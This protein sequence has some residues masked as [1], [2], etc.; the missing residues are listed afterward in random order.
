MPTRRPGRRTRHLNAAKGRKERRVLHPVGRHR[1]RDE[2]LPGV[3]PRRVPRQGDPAPVRRPRVEQ[4]HQVL[5]AALHGLR[6]QEADLDVVRA[7]QQPRGDLLPADAV[8]DGRPE[9]RRD[10]DPRQRQEVR[11]GAEGHQRRRRHQHRR[12]P[13]GVPRR[14]R[15]LPQR[16]GD[17]AARRGR[18]RH[19]QPA[20]QPLPPVRRLARRGRQEVRGDRQ[21]NAIT[22]N[23]DLP[24]HQGEPMWWKGATGNSTDMVFGVPKGDRDERSPRPRS[25]AIHQTTSATTRGW[26]TRAGSPTSTTV[27]ATNRCS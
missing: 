27:D 6:H 11:A 16:R 3:R 25:S 13:V 24:A 15:R 18:H 1:A 14:R 26:A 22:Y 8:R 5:R 12:P 7:R 2:R 9:V 4:L 21:Q 17:G 19:H 20:V 10:Q 23:G